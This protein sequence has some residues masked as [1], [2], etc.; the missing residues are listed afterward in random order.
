MEKTPDAD[1]TLPVPH[2]RQWPGV[3][4]ISSADTRLSVLVLV[5]PQTRDEK[6]EHWPTV[7]CT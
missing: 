7:A 4:M 1:P 2:H 3:P 6:Y 5:W